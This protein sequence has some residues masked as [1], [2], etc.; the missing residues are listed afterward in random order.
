MKQIKIAENLPNDKDFNTLYA[1]AGWGEV[2][3]EVLKT[4]RQLTN[5]AVSVYN[6]KKIIAMGRIFGDGLHFGIYD[7][8]VLQDYRGKDFGTVIM[9][10]LLDWFD[11]QPNSPHLTLGSVSGSEKFYEKFGF[12]CCPF[13]DATTGINLGAGMKYCGR[14]KT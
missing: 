13:N 12:K 1:D 11:K 6:D 3:P 14:S 9:D 7:V 10:K 5:F 8:T 2:K 4:I